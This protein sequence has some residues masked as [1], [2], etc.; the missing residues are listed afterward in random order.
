MSDRTFIRVSVDA[1]KELKK[2]SADEEV[3]MI[4]MLEMVI[5]EYKRIKEEYK[6]SKEETK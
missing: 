4:D 5:E 3:S 1:R 2:L 6:K